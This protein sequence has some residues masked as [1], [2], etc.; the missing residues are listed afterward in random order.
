MHLF[1]P[2]PPNTHTHTSA[3]THHTAPHLCATMLAIIAAL[4]LGGLLKSS[5]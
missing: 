3:P 5:L 1:H 2:P 4:L